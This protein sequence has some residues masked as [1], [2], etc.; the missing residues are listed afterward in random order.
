MPQSGDRQHP[1]LT[2]SLP[3]DFGPSSGWSPSKFL[4]FDA[5]ND[6]PYMADVECRF[7]GAGRE[8]TIQLG[9]FPDLITRV[10]VP[11]RYLDSEVVITGRTPHRFKCVCSGGPIEPRVVERV[12]MAGRTPGGDAVI[13]ISEPELADAMPRQ[14]PKTGRPIVDALQQ[15][16]DHDWPNKAVSLEDIRGMLT[17]ELLATE[18]PPAEELDRWGGWAMRKFDAS[19]FFR[20]EKDSERW[21]LVDPDGYG[22]YSLGV[23]CIRPNGLAETWGNEDLFVELP[24]NDGPFDHLWDAR[25]DGERTLFDGMRYNLM[26]A[27][28]EGW[29]AKWMELCRRRMYEWGF[30]T[31]GNWSHPDFWRQAEIPHVIQLAGF[32]TTQK[33]IF[34]DFPD[35]FSDEYELNSRRFAEQLDQK[36]DDQCLIGYFLRNEPHWAFGQYNLAER[37]LVRAE[38]FAS[39]DRLVE[40]LRE[41]HGDI[42]GLNAAWG[43]DFGSFDAL[44]A[45]P[46]AE[47]KLASQAARADLKQFNR[48]LIERYVRAP[49]EECKRVDPNHMNL[50]LRY[51]WIAHDDLLAGVDAFDVFSLN[52]YASK[53]DADVVR[54]CCEAANAPVLIGEFH[55]GALDHGLPA[56]GLRMVVGQQDRADSYRYYVEQAAAMPCVV[57]THY[58]QWNDQPVVGRSDGENW[59]IGLVDVCQRPYDEFVAGARRSHARIYPV[60]AGQVRPFDRLP[61]DL[62]MA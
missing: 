44:A 23:N 6:G 3:Y 60:A 33:R 53:P 45:A 25:D 4:I 7:V 24:A 54:R 22:F 18:P 48:L 2:I 34:R 39:R 49:S 43:T 38:R 19:G 59:Q 17:E 5:I 42:A 56:G 57:G 61:N 50:G 62:P 27:F 26:R 20:A 1:E 55:T 13:R 29:F 30:N 40:W 10:V 16:A 46:V 32:P 21:W 31:V 11:L 58:F 47:Q 15:W 36:L 41:Q 9:L 51:A 52:C 8:M 37:M 35:V 28:G 12:H 14:W